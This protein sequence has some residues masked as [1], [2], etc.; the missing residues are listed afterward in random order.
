M[1][2]LV[3]GLPRLLLVFVACGCAAV[4]GAVRAAPPGTL[5]LEGHDDG[6]LDGRLEAP[7]PNARTDGLAV[8]CRLGSDGESLTTTTG[9]GGRWTI[10]I[11]AAWRAK[12]DQVLHVTVGGK[13]DAATAL[14]AVR[15]MPLPRLVPPAEWG[16]GREVD[17]PESAF[18]SIGRTPWHY[19]HDAALI[20]RFHEHL[21]ARKIDPPSLLAAAPSPP[22]TVRRILIE[23]ELAPG[24]WGTT[25]D[26]QWI[27]CQRMRYGPEARL[28]LRVDRG[29]LYR[30]WIRFIGYKDGVTPGVLTLFR[31]D[32]DPNL[33]LVIDEYSSRPA[34]ADG[35][36]WHDTLVDLEPGDYEILL[37]QAVRYY[38]TPQ[39][40]PSPN[41][42]VDC[43]YLTDELWRDAP[44]DEER[45]TLRGRVKPV[46]AQR[47]ESAPLAG[48][49]RDLWKLWQVRPIDWEAARGQPRLFAE[50]H[51]FWRREIAAIAEADYQA[52]PLDPVTGGV[53]DY[54]DPRRQVVFDP[55]WNMLGNPHR[56]RT[57]RNILEDDLD[58]AAKDAFYETLHPGTFPVVEG[59]WNREGG[60]LTAWDAAT[61]GLAAGSFTVP[62]PGT[63]HVWV[64]FK[65]IN[66]F[67]YF[68][69]RAEP[70]SGPAA[71]WE[72]TERLYPGGRVA[73]AKVGTVTVP[74]RTAE[75]RAAAGKGVFVEAGRPI[76]AATRGEWRAGDGGLEA[77]GPDARL[78]AKCGLAK[79]ADVRVRARLSVTGLAGSGAAFTF[80]ESNGAKDN[81]VLL[82]GSG[83]GAAFGAADVPF[84]KPAAIAAGERFDFEWVREGKAARV[85]VAGQPVLAWDLADEPGPVFGFRPGKATLKVHDFSASGGID[86][87]ASI[88]RQV[89]IS[90]W[91]DKYLN[92]RTYRG[93][94][95]LMLTDDPDHVPEGTT[96]PKASP[97][98]FFSQLGA[99]GFKPDRG[100]MLNVSEGR[101]LIGQNWM[102]SAESAEPVLDLV[103][104][105]DSVRAGQ[106]FFR[107]G[108]Y[109]PL[110]L[111]IRPAPLASGAKQFPDAVRWR[112]VAFAP[113]TAGREG[114]SP[115]FLLRRPYLTLP[116]LAPAQAWLTFDTTGV[117][118][119]TY[120]SRIEIDCRGPGGREFPRRTVKVRLRVAPVQ[121]APQRPILVHGWVGPP[122]GEAYE[123]DWFRRFSVAMGT[124]RSKAEMKRLG[125]RLQIFATGRP[126]EADVRKMI[127][128]AKA[129]GLD[130]DDW[131]F[132]VID[133]PA[134]QNEQ[135][136]AEYIA[137][138]KMIRGI[139]PR[140]RMTMN[141]GE[142]ARAATFAILQP[143]VDLW[144]PYALHLAF[145]PSGRA[146]LEKPWIWYTTPCYGDKTPGMSSQI[147]EQVRSVL[148]Q[149][150]DCLGTAFFAP[151]Y[152]W[153]D[154]WDTAYEHIPDVS[155]FVLPSRHGP[156]ATPTWE[157]LL[158]AVQHANLARMVREQA[159]P[160]DAAAK[161]LWEYGDS[162]AILTWLSRGR[163]R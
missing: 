1:A 12:S 157:A 60:S 154:P 139:D 137:I 113:Y 140:A 75:E 80:R 81:L 127:A 115:F 111:T 58:P 82:E 147:Y 114:W 112:A 50:S 77:T 89:T 123:R 62:R 87:G 100:Y 3:R 152:P 19:G 7:P 59:Q 20:A 131:A 138:G 29:G 93:V 39:N 159:K 122:P 70:L 86:D 54:R 52:P 55:D 95:S 35:P 14:F 32:R 42:Q 126:T 69:V 143:Y 22:D 96:A 103:M 105:R 23:P 34:G 149:P 148:R 57:Q 8:V 78:L 41:L 94:Y 48:V 17:E 4:A 13:D 136:L 108:C 133:E 117:P 40:A 142:P 109:D 88:A 90:L 116:S 44:G 18:Q 37:S 91:M 71:V 72:R 151:Y 134:G 118:P 33:P 121:I 163:P 141:P 25:D 61:N 160:D 110:T 119:G 106:L 101:D 47:T 104:A 21:R 73:W 99:Q 2:D 158:E 31:V 84:Q 28:P 129:Q 63:W 10:E 45:E 64:Q 36:R 38:Q 144:N 153:R 27:F 145:G 135:E 6:R 97:R 130:Y 76:L 92:A 26:K 85:L 83:R 67:E 51:A 146:Y 66:Y 5:R 120:E 74:E 161:S 155:V 49:D 128:A 125:V 98:R 30:L 11:P 9:S 24:G 107:S 56:I 16:L 68:G 79:G 150:A 102:P 53:P 43:L 124:P 15:K 156:V 132:S 46:K 162:E 65:N